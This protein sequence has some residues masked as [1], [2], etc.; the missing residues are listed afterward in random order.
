MLFKDDERAR[1]EAKA[2]REN[3]GWY[4]WTHDLVEL[5]GP[6]AEEFLDWVLVNRIAGTPVGRGTYT[7]CRGPRAE[8]SWRRSAQ[9]WPA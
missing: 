3:A 4:R 8:R 9:T 6:D 5:T 7:R 1:A 2:V